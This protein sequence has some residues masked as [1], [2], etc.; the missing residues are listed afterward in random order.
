MY[1]SI[2]AEQIKTRLPFKVTHHHAEGSYSGIQDSIS[3]IIAHHT[4]WLC[5]DNKSCLR[6]P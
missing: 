4:T 5:G 1:V 3:G 6:L 2:V